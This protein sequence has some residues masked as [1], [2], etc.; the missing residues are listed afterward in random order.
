[1]EEIQLDMEDVKRLIGDLQLGNN[2]LQKRLA[3]QT[4][5]VELLKAQLAAQQTGPKIVPL[6]D[7]KGEA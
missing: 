2:L 3:M 6:K 4:Q 1:M 7:G 5:A